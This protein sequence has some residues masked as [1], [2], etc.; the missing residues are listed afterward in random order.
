MKRRG[1][2]I[3][4]QAWMH[5]RPSRLGIILMERNGRDRGG[6]RI[7]KANVRR[8][9]RDGH[10][11]E[12]PEVQFRYRLNVWHQEEPT[13]SWKGDLQL[14]WRGCKSGIW[15]VLH[16]WTKEKTLKGET[17][18]TQD[19]FQAWWNGTTRPRN[20][21]ETPKHRDPELWDPEQV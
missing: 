4:L 11:E 14:D 19:P 18:T 7:L 20:Q 13:W 10:A 16:H 17:G 8:W 12:Q 5:L 21:R 15:S 3:W 1:Y 6:A 2:D 9:E